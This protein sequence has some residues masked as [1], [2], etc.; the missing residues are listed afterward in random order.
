MFDE[1]NYVH[2]SQGGLENQ[3]H[4]TVLLGGPGEERD[5]SL[6]SGKAVI[7]A[8]RTLGHYVYRGDPKERCWQ[9]DSRT[10]VVFLALHGEYG[11]DGQVQERLEQEGVPY[12]GTGIR[13]SRIAFDKELTK[14]AF[15]KND[16]PTPRWLMLNDPGD[17]TPSGIAAPWVLKPIRQGSS[18]GLQLV[19]AAGQWD[20]ALAAAR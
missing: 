12:T 19:N 3:Y 15:E 4:I 14:H 8:L 17:P 6:R 10:K 5:V 7:K 13:G 18:V 9:L 1:K 20:T 16:L 11:E 2:F